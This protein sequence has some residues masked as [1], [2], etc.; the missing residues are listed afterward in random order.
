MAVDWTQAQAAVIGSALIDPK[1]VP[2]ILAEMRAED[3]S[4]TFSRYFETLKDLTA[5]N[6][7]VDPVT[8]L[9]RLGQDYKELTMDLV[10]NT[11]TAS[12]VKAYVQL[13][14]EQSRLRAL[15]DIGAELMGAVTLEDA[16]ELL[17]RG[18]AASLETA[19]NNTYSAMEMA[20][21]WINSVNRQERPDYITC[22]IACLDSAIHTVAGN[23]H[24]IAGFTG[25]GKSALVLQIA[26]HIAKARKIGYFSNEMTK[27]EFLNR[28]MAM[29]SG[30]DAGSI[31]SREL[32]ADEMTRTATAASEIFK[33]KLDY[34]A[35]AGY[36]VDDIRALTLQKGYEVIVVDYLQNVKPPNSKNGD[37]FRGVTEVS[38]GLQTLAH[39]LGVVVIA[40]SQL[41]RQMEE[42]GF[43]P[44]PPLSSL[45]E[46][47]QIEQ[48]ADAVVFVHAP[49]Q[50]QYPRFRVLDVAK[51]RSGRLER[52]FTAFEGNLQH[53][54]APTNEEFRIWSEVMRKRRGLKAD[55]VAAIREELEKKKYPVSLV[56]AQEQRYEAKKTGK[57]PGGGDNDQDR[58]QDQTQNQGL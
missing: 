9:A 47:G 13:C 36:T 3:F 29:L 48:D 8:I 10:S 58:G 11:P 27:P 35:A 1:C 39:S 20:A 12:N 56:H 49:L 24:I 22:G 4:S 14:K 42:E 15:R 44:V 16:R 54:A 18:A 33:A 25:N 55:E 31:Q 46:S 21:D 5:E 38:R 30:T 52:F 50:R 53:F 40:T 26:W 41:S 45:R 34:E 37:R 32:E 23:Y 17:S 51:N 28:S 57:Q 43:R 6:V 2:L 19:R 7:P